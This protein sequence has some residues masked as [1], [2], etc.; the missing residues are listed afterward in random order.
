MKKLINLA[1]AAIFLCGTSVFTSCTTTDNPAQSGIN[2]SEMIIGKWITTNIEGKNM[3]TNDK[4]VFTFVSPTKAYLSASYTTDLGSGEQWI[5]KREI[6]V[7]ISGDTITLTTRTDEH[8]IVVEKLIVQTITSS[9]LSTLHDVS[10][11]YDGKVIAS[12]KGTPLRFAKITT[13]YSQDIIGLWECTALTGTETYNDADSRLE[14]FADGTYKY[15]HKNTAGEWEAVINREF[16]NYFV[17]GTLLGTRWKNTGEEELRE[18]W[19]IASLA[20][21]QMVW[22]ALREK[23]DDTTVQ[24]EMRWKKIE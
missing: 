17:D 9:K 12:G 10:I 18:W 8:T 19:E 11:Y 22:T 7:V 21:G 1:M 23:T 16:Q 15:W 4:I 20:N 13:D 5:D 14:F 24:Q 3:Q 6:D 2:L